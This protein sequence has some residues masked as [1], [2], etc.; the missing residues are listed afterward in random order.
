MVVD[1]PTLVL[2]A[3]LLELTYRLEG[4]EPGDRPVRVFAQLV[5]DA[6]GTVVGNQNTPVPLR[7]VAGEHRIEVPLEQVVLS[8]EP[9]EAVTLQIVATSVSFGEPRLGGTARFSEI[10]L[11][12]PVVE[13]P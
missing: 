6:T 9:G 5:D 3:P 1:E 4:V 10:D 7:D 13:V 11:E 8:L 2:G 12:L